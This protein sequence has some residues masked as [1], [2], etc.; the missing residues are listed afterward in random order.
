MMA[1]EMSERPDDDP[2]GYHFIFDSAGP[3]YLIPAMTC[4]V[5]AG[6]ALANMVYDSTGRRISPLR[7]SVPTAGAPLEFRRI[8]ASA[9]I[10]CALYRPPN[11]D[12]HGTGGESCS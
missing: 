3:L 4:D 11:R 6:F 9:R 8:D 7:P 12:L 10:T 1:N 5:R 2:T